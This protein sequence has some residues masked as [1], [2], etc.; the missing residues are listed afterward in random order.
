MPTFFKI[1]LIL[2]DNNVQ[3]VLVDFLCLAVKIILVK[4]VLKLA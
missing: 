4:I 3:F 1:L 2:F